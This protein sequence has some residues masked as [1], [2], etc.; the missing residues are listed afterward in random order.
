MNE[1]ER[2]QDPMGGG[3]LFDYLAAARQE[4]RERHLSVV[5][6]P[7]GDPSGS[8]ADGTPVD[9]NQASRVE[10]PVAAVAE[11]PVEDVVEQSATADAEDAEAA[12]GE[13]PAEEPLAPVITASS[14][15]NR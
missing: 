14:V 12:P 6:S 8:E 9:A 3:T 13:D 5:P 4:V 10:A 15:V 2:S 11:P 1:Q 7:D